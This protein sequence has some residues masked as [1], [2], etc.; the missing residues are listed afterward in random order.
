MS[1][2]P[3]TPTEERRPAWRRACLAYREMRQAGATTSSARILGGLSGKFY[4]ITY[5]IAVQRTYLAKTR[6]YFA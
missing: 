5:R 3:S 1:E 2:R 4:R 6:I